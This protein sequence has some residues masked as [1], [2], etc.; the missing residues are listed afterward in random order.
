MFWC[1]SFLK[2]KSKMATWKNNDY[3]QVQIEKQKLRQAQV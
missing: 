3:E 2:L 1:Q